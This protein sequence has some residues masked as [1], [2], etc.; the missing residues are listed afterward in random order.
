H[1]TSFRPISNETKEAFFRLFH[2][3][4]NPTSAYNT[5]IEKMQLKFENDEAILADKAISEEVENFN[6]NKKGNALMQPYIAPTNTDSGQL[7]VLAIVTNLIKCCHALQQASKLVYMDTTAGLDILNTTMTILSTS[8]SIGGLPFA[9]MLTSDKTS[10]TFTKALDMLKCVM[11]ISAFNEYGPKIGPKVFMTNNSAWKWLWDSKYGINKDDYVALIE[12]LKKIIFARTKTRLEEGRH[13]KWAI[14]YRQHLTIQDNH[15]N[16]FSE[17]GIWVIKDAIFAIAYNKLDNFIVHC[18]QLS[19]WQI[20]SLN[21]IQLPTMSIVGRHSYAYLALGEKYKDCSFYTNLYQEQID[22]ESMDTIVEHT[23][24]KKYASG[25]SAMS[26]TQFLNNETVDANT[27][28][29]SVNKI[30]N[31]SVNESS[32]NESRDNNNNK[33]LIKDES[34]HKFIKAYKKCRLIQDTHIHPAIRGGKRIKV[35]VAAVARCKGTSNKE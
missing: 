4:H 30:V 8:T 1:V 34:V 10:N 28:N 21:D 35:Q 17:A 2:A 22:K 33:N 15:T 20:G 24:G 13:K 11:S 7:F 5:Y 32:I 18:F 31:K 6:S 3:G 29:K 19:G 26:L 27:I 16:N 23:I 9:I 12:Y 25:S 14:A